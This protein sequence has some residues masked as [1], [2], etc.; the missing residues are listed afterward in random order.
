MYIIVCGYHPCV[1]TDG[2]FGSRV[3]AAALEALA[4]TS[5]PLS[6]YRVA[7]VIGAQPIQVLVTL[8]SLAPQYVQRHAGGWMLVDDSLRRFLRDTLAKRESER[9]SE[10]DELIA[11]LRLKSRRSR[12]A[13]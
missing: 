2:L 8:K 9:R 13:N 1:R 4:A 10:K 7:K 6:A 11:R 3:R 12:G 5:K